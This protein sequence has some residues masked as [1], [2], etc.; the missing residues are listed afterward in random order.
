MNNNI[1]EPST[2]QGPT[3]QPQNNLNITQSINPQQNTLNNLNNEQPINQPPLPPM[4]PKKSKGPLVIIILLILIILGLAGYICYDKFIAKDDTPKSIDRKDITDNSNKKILKK[5]ESKDVVYTAYKGKSSDNMD[6]L[7]PE[8]NIDSIYAKKINLEIRTK[9]LVD[10]KYDDSN[11]INCNSELCPMIKY[12]YYINNNILSLLV[13]VDYLTDPINHEYYTYNIDV[14]TGEEIT[15]KDLVKLKNINEKNFSKKLSDVFK[16][17]YAFDKYYDGKNNYPDEKKFATEMYNKTTDLNNC[18][19]GNPM[20]LNE[21]G[22]LIVVLGVYYYA[23]GE[24][25]TDSIVNID[26][27]Q[28]IYYEDYKM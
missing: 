14:Y 27:K 12:K 16:E 23:G 20:F 4:P 7:I 26:Q 17:A 8:I 6:V 11:V 1:P 2:N 19:I 18:S 28:F 24:G 15:N 10:Y 13:Y 3:I 9:M 5:N 22:E 25:T 21:N